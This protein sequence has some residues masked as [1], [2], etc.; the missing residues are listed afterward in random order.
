MLGVSGVTW[1]D[2]SVAG[3]TVRVTIGELTAPKLALTFVDPTPPA[4]A[5]P[6]EP[7]VLL[8]AATLASEEAQVTIE[9]RFWV[10]LSVYTPVAVNC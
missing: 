10:D 6:A 1:I 2:T 8:I 5:R 3:V 9:V 7:A 4:E